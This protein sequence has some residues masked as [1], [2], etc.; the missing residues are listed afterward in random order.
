MDLE[1]IDDVKLETKNQ[2]KKATMPKELEAVVANFTPLQKRYAE[3]RSKGLKQSDAAQKAGSQ[4]QG[5][6]A[7]GRV[8]YNLEQLDGMKEYIAYLYEKRSRAAVLDEIEIV[9]KLRANYE[10]AVAAGRIDWA[11]KAV[12]L[13]GMMVGAFKQVPNSNKEDGTKAKTKNNVNAFKNDDEEVS[14]SD[15]IKTINS[16]IQSM[17]LRK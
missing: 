17:D 13:M 11:N 6:A 12:E 15:K 14:A 5:R 1:N 8:G 2:T 10:E 16:L 9:E 3:Y 7:L 4:A